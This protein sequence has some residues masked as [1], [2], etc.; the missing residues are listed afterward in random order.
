MFAGED[1]WQ[2]NERIDLV[3]NPDYDGPRKPVNGG[4]SFV[5][6]ETP[7]AS[8]AD[9]LGGNLDVTDQIPDSA[10]ATF[11]DELGDRAIDQ[12]AA[13]FQSFTIPDSPAALRRRG[14]P[15]ASRRHLDGHQP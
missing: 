2:H 4:V 9:L 5:F 11:K 1:A 7:D 13:I 14:G 3:V 15:A 12:A 8:Y 10:F 6:Y